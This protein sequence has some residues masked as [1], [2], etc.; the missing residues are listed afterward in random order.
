MPYLSET[1][2]IPVHAQLPSPNHEA[3][4]RCGWDLH[5]AECLERLTTNAKVATVLGSIQGSSDTVESRA[6]DEA[7]LDKIGTYCKINK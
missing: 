7:V 6:A 3:N 2:T 1:G 4:I 5:I